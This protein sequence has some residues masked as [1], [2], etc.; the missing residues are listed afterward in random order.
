MTTI[1]SEFRKLTVVNGPNTWIFNDARCSF[2]FLESNTKISLKLYDDHKNTT[3]TE[4]LTALS[5]N[6]T[7]PANSTEA[8]TLMDAAIAEADS[9]VTQEEVDD[10]SGGASPGGSLGYLVKTYAEMLGLIG[11]S[12]S[13]SN[14]VGIINGEGDVIIANN[15]ATAVIISDESGVLSIK[16]L[17]GDWDS[18]TSFQDDDSGATAN[19][20]SFTAG[21]GFVVAQQYLITDAAAAQIQGGLP[22]ASG[23]L[24]QATT[25][26]R[27]AINGTG[28]FFNAD[29]QKVGDYSGVSGFS[30]Q[31]GQ[32]LTD[33]EGDYSDGD[34]VIYNCLH[35]KVENSANFNGSAPPS[36]PTAYTLLEKSITNGY[37]EEWDEVLYDF[38]N[39]WLQGRKDRRGNVAETSLQEESDIGESCILIFQWG[40]DLVFGNIM[41]PGTLYCIN[42]SGTIYINTSLNEAGIT[43]QNNSGDIH[44]NILSCAGQIAADNN[45]GTITNNNAQANI[46]VANNTG[47]VINNTCIDAA[48]I[49]ASDNTGTIAYNFVAGVASLRGTTNAGTIQQNVVV[50]AI[51]IDLS[52]TIGNTIQNKFYNSAGKVSGS[53]VD[54][55]GNT[56]TIEYG[57]ITAITPP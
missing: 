45:S 57:L 55:D 16:D 50:N 2:S 29:F 41:T 42:Q 12:I 36:R 33:D 52:Q 6:G 19:I 10:N 4:L 48:G 23:I 40:N 43:A 18:A 25:E 53:F 3:I 37:I 32:W 15:G 30:E 31:Q 27:L 26:N 14:L 39:D 8:T 22:I 13:Y 47:S 35:Y 24:V 51:D 7:T 49:I 1:T 9:V 17:V 38:P 34:V 28:K 56:V 46:S 54:A 21:A 44:Q 5:I 20:V 11:G